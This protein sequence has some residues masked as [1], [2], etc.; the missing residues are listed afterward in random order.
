MAPEMTL[1]NGKNDLKNAKNGTKKSPIKEVTYSAFDHFAYHY[2]SVHRYSAALP[3]RCFC[4]W[5]CRYVPRE[6][7]CRDLGLLHE[8]SVV[9]IKPKQ[10]EIFF[11]N[12][13]LI[14]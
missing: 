6:K 7:V 12:I 9:P 13:R 5:R 2:A 14:V 4:V 10:R 3:M 8:K 11:V 1:K